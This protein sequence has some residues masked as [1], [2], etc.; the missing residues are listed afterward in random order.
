MITEKILILDGAMG[1]M[2]QKHGLMDLAVD[3][4]PQPVHICDHLF[5]QKGNSILQLFCIHTNPSFCKYSHSPCRVR[6]S[7]IF[8][9]D[10]V[11]WQYRAISLTGSK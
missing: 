1:T 5:R 8:A 11:M 6:W 4:G 9:L 2:I 3:P 10:S 7:R